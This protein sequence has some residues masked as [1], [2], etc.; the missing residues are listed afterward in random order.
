[1]AVGGVGLG[2]AFADASAAALSIRLWAKLGEVVVGD[3]GLA[4]GEEEDDSCFGLVAVGVDGP[5]GGS[6]GA[7][8]AAAA[9]SDDAAVRAAPFDLAAGEA[10]PPT[11]TAKRSMNASILTSCDLLEDFKPNTSDSSASRAAS[12]ESQ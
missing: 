6:G 12:D 10:R 11:D 2:A 9:S 8:A 3:R 5:F 1:M 7:A 4:L